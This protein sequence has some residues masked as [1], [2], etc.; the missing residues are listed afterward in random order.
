MAGATSSFA[1][2]TLTGFLV[3][4]AIDGS[5]PD[6]DTLKL[7]QFNALKQGQD[8]KV[9]LRNGNILSGRFVKRDTLT[10][11]EYSRNYSAWMEGNPESAELPVPG[12]TVTLST[13]GNADEHN[14]EIVAELV[15]FD[16]YLML[17]RQQG[18]S[19][20]LRTRIITTMKDGHGHAIDQRTLS[21]LMDAGEI[22][23]M[24]A[25]VFQTPNGQERLPLERVQQIERHVAKRA[26]W[27]FG[28][29]GLFV[30]VIGI[31]TVSSGNFHIFSGGFGRL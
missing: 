15:G 30:D 17:L 28:G 11:T 19:V 3:G 29:V 6:R 16:G 21:S 26:K 5:T 14:L 18:R 2:C 8:V 10:A 27:I 4:S 22:P 7:A 23:C 31:W 25:L 20:V 24:T 1:G 12:D 13:K 9:T